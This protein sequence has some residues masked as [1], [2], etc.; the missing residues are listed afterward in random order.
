MMMYY[1]AYRGSPL[2]LKRLYEKEHKTGSAA[3][4]ALGEREKGMYIVA[5]SRKAVVDFYLYHMGF[6]W[7]ERTIGIETMA[8]DSTV[9]R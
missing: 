7:K 3:F 8:V 9:A 1:L 4:H 2:T 6:T 5:P